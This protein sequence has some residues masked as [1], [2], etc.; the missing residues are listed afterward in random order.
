M[1][2]GDPIPN[3]RDVLGNHP[4]SF[5]P[6]DVPPIPAAK[7]KVVDEPVTEEDVKKEETKKKEEEKK[8][9]AAAP[10]KEEE[11]KADA[12]AKE[13]KK[14]EAAPAKEEAKAEAAPAKE[15]KLL[16]EKS[17]DLKKKGKDPISEDEY[18]P[19]VF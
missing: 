13:E 5:V 19:W 9:D 14:A 17:S 12:P 4:K 8:A 1:E 6:G 2:G 16:T 18:D 11:K 10:K 15:E 7:D 3:R